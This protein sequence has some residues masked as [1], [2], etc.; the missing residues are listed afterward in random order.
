M[1]DEQASSDASSRTEL[2]RG[3]LSASHCVAEVDRERCLPPNWHTLDGQPL[4][5]RP[6]AGRPGIE[7]HPA[8]S[9]MIAGLPRDVQHTLTRAQLAAISEAMQPQVPTHLVQ[10][11]VSLPFI[12]RRYYL[13]FFFGRER[14][15]LQRLRHEGQLSVRL[16][17]VVLSLFAGLALSTALVAVALGAYIIKSALGIDLLDG[18]SILHDFVF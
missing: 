5:Q 16:T 9:R 3:P 7:W 6:T 8:F 10:F 1:R 11:R 18:P 12:W 2:A 13:A 17:S 14:R 15:N 4:G